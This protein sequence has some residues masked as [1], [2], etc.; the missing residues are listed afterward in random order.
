MLANLHTAVPVVCV[1]DPSENDSDKTFTVPDQ[2]TWEIAS[3][4]VTVVASAD[5]G[6]RLLGVDVLDGNSTVLYS[7]R[8]AAVQVASATEYYRFLPGGFSPSETVATHHFVPLGSMILPEGWSVRVWDS[9]AVKADADHM[10]VT[11]LVYERGITR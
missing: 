4:F 11:L 8:A 2:R 1:K 3:I 6:N 10:D 5:V 9:A 7:T